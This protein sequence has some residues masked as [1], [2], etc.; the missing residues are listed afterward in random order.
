MSPLRVSYPNAQN[1]RISYIT[2]KRKI[3]VVDGI[4]LVNTVKQVTLARES[5]VD[6]PGGSIIT[7]SILESGKRRQL[8]RSG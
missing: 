1:L 8:K 4:K 3:K 2:R 6:D 7:T 5:I